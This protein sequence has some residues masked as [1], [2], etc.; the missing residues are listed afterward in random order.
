M[1]YNDEPVCEETVSKPKAECRAESADPRP[2]EMGRSFDKPT[3]PARK[4]SP[5]EVLKPEV[6][7]PSLRAQ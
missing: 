2:K 3:V 7:K 6:L 5:P 1:R 4:E